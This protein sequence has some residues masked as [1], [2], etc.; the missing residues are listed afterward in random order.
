MHSQKNTQ[1]RVW[2]FPKRNGCRMFGSVRERQ[3]HG[4]KKVERF[5]P[6]SPKIHEDTQ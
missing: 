1:T 4:A 2:D 3:R 5:F 6:P